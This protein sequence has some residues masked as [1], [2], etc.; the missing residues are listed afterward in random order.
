MLPSILVNMFGNPPTR[1]LPTLFRTR[2]VVLL[3]RTP[4]FLLRRQ[5]DAVDPNRV[6]DSGDELELKKKDLNGNDLCIYIA[7]K[8]SRAYVLKSM[9]SF[10]VVYSRASFY[11]CSILE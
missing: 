4:I 6:K 8:K 10:L 1:L 3:A 11:C 2:L 5:G 9:R 7:N